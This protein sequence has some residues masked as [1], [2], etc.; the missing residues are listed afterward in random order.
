MAPR[1]PLPLMIEL[2]AFAGDRLCDAVERSLSALGHR[3]QRASSTS[4]VTAQISVLVVGAP[5]AADGEAVSALHERAGWPCLGLVDAAQLQSAGELIGCCSEVALWPCAQ[6]ELAMRLRRIAPAPGPVEMPSDGF[7]QGVGRL[8]LIGASDRFLALLRRLE[9]FAACDAPVL[10]E[11]ETGTG[12]ELAARAVHYH[13]RRHDQPFI[14]INC[15]AL[16]EHLVENELFG[17]EKGAFTGAVTH[18]SGLVEQAR[19]GTLFLDEVEAL[20]PRAQVSLLRFLQEQEYRH[21]GGHQIQHGD[22]RLIA[23][24]NAGLA[25][26]VGQ[27]QFREDFLFR[28][29]VL[30]ARLPPLRERS[31]DVRLLA[32]HFLDRLQGRYGG[33]RRRLGAA[34]LAWMERYAWP[35]NVRELENFLHREFV[36]ADGAVIDS[37]P[38]GVADADV[39]PGAVAFDA[40]FQQAKALAIDAF[41]CRYLDWLMAECHGNVTVAARRAGKERRALGKLLRKHRI[42][43]N[44]YSA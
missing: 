11:G 26:L 4:A 16:P 13:S 14:P 39:G 29:N 38:P 40:G 19:G 17:H 32:G 9:R 44:R 34:T 3:V 22:V 37:R 24:S 20:T 8:N 25:A 15:G 12:K 18:Q 33:V 36:L 42:D 27:G 41:E 23:A 6:Q 2:L 10:L 30:F 1:D 7:L 5:M 35:G 28:L 21:L 31:G 43:R